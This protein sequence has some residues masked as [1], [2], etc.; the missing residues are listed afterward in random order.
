MRNA[1]LCVECGNTLIAPGVFFNVRLTT[2]CVNRSKNIVGPCTVYSVR[3]KVYFL[4]VRLKTSK[5]RNSCELRIKTV[6]YSRLF[7]YGGHV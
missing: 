2:C 4:A 5:H 6:I 7:T 3:S 1:R